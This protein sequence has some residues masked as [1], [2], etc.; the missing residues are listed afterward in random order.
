VQ[1]T[2]LARW[3]P[4]IDDLGGP[5]DVSNE[6]LE[7]GN[8][9]DRGRA[10]LANS[11]YGMSEIETSTHSGNLGFTGTGAID[12]DYDF[13]ISMTSLFIIAN[14]D[15]TPYA[16]DGIEVSGHLS[17]E[18][19]SVKAADLVITPSAGVFC[20]QTDTNFTCI[21]TPGAVA[22]T[23]TI[24]N[25]PSGKG[26]SICS[27]MLTPTPSG[28]ETILS[29]AAVTSDTRGADIWV[30]KTGCAPPP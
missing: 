23:I 29:L 14:L 8:A 20:G 13:D 2:W 6:P 25:Y 24:S 26:L 7:T 21:V 16:T 5:V 3:Y 19:P 11:L 1:L 4:H 9:H 18:L 12:H 30:T 15:T 28:D 17:S 22:P 27:D 10:E